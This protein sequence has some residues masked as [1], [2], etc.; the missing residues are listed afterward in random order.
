M[1]LKLPIITPLKGEVRK[2]IIDNEIGLIYDDNSDM[3]LF[4]LILK[5]KTDSNIKN[6]LADNAINLYE[7]NYSYGLVYGRLVKHLEEMANSSDNQV[8]LK[9]QIKKN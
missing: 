2:L 3:D 9:I 8:N 6:N 1:A 5:L 4:E 7:K